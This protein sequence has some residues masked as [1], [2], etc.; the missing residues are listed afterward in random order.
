MYTS[1]VSTCRIGPFQNDA[2][3]QPILIHW[4]AFCMPLHEMCRAKQQKPL[5]GLLAESSKSW[6]PPAE[7]TRIL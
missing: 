5:F 2:S 3:Q 7:P 1:K 4:M 6:C